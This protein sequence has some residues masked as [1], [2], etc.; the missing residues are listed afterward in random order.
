MATKR[1]AAATKLTPVN[2]RLFSED[3]EEIKQIAEEQGGSWQVELR[4]TVRRALR[5]QRREVT[6]I[7]E[8]RS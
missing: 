4:M 6:I 8:K 3:V 5:G 7:A 1:K 2:V